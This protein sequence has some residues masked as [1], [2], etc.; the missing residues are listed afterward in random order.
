[1]LTTNLTL[2]MTKVSI[3]NPRVKAKA[4]NKVFYI[5]RAYLEYQFITVDEAYVRIINIT[6]GIHFIW[7]P[8][9]TR[10]EKLFHITKITTIAYDFHNGDLLPDEAYSQIINLVS[11]QN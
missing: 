9:L 2:I 10:V 7:A 4:L 5:C 6:V 8:Q 1:M 11:N 3:L